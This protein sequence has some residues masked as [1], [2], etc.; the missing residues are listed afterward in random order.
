[1]LVHKYTHKEVPKI[2]E[3]TGQGRRVAE[4]AEGAEQ[5]LKEE[6]DIESKF[7]TRGEQCWKW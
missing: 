6:E 4:D 7:L 2:G 3:E 5:S 1:M